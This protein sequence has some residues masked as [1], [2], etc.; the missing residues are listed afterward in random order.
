MLCQNIVYIVYSTKYVMHSS[1][2]R[3]TV[4]CISL[5][6]YFV[7][8]SDTKNCTIVNL[9]YQSPVDLLIFEIIVVCP[10]LD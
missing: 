2:A 4:P 9:W 10:I 1:Q 7:V 8:I 6:S 5:A 3:P